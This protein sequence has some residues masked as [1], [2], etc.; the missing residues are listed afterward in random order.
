MRR[1][2]VRCRP[3]RVGAGFNVELAREL[4]RA[5]WPELAADA[6]RGAPPELL[7]RRL[8]EIAEGESEAARILADAPRA[9]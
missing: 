2:P 8:R 6:E 1:E 7:L 4:E 3:R 5:G 9:A